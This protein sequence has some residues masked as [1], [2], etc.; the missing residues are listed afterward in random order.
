VVLLKWEV[1]HLMLCGLKVSIV[2][3]EQTNK[4]LNQN[5]FPKGA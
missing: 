5:W 2:K 1:A 3:K 4:F